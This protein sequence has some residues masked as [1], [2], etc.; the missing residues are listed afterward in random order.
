MYIYRLFISTT[1]R[2]STAPPHQ[3]P[4][5]PPP[6]RKKEVLYS[7]PY[8]QD[9]YCTLNEC[10]IHTRTLT[11]GLPFYTKHFTIP[12]ALL[13]LFY[14]WKRYNPFLMGNRK[15]SCERFKFHNR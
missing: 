3:I 14:N 8:I 15:T 12:N 4:P 5:P 1:I 6:Q 9:V 13:E 2:I 10:D 11:R 7:V